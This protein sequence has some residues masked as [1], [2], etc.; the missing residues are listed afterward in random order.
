MLPIDLLFIFLSVFKWMSKR[1]ALPLSK[2]GCP[3]KSSSSFNLC[4]LAQCSR[5]IDIHGLHFHPSPYKS[6]LK[7]YK[8]IYIYVDRAPGPYVRLD[9]D[10]VLQYTACPVRSSG[11]EF[12]A[13]SC[14]RFPC[15]LLLVST[16]SATCK[17]KG[18]VF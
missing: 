15:W 16:I 7:N 13:C 17:H 14:Y 18:V 10:F 11:S 8:T 5:Y 6:S 9:V 4:A 1:F 2:I 3:N 12:Y